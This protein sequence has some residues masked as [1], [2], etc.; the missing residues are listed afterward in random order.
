MGE[1]IEEKLLK[2]M[3]SS[4]LKKSWIVKPTTRV[5]LEAVTC[6]EN[7]NVCTLHVSSEIFYLS[8]S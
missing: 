6:T 8:A 4:W 2:E 7:V 3:A 5:I 1:K